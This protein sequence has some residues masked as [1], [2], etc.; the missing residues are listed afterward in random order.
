MS[1]VTKTRQKR[2][3]IWLMP[4]EQFAELVARSQT[5]SEMLLALDY[6]PRGGAF[7]MLKERI[8]HERLGVSHLLPNGSFVKQYRWAPR[9]HD[10]VFCENSTYN[11]GS[12]LKKKMLAVGWVNECA[13]CGI[14]PAWHGKLLSLQVDHINGERTDN[15]E[16]NLRLICPNCHSQTDTFAGKRNRQEPEVAVRVRVPRSRKVVRPS[17][18]ELQKL[19]WE[20]PTVKI[21]RRFGVSDVA[22]GKWA[23]EYDLSKPP[24]GYWAKQSA[25]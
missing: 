22:V 21:A 3:K 25:V 23:K 8:A 11:S 12:N 5:Y 17:A 20:L 1:K 6:S 2:S 16:E 10:E 13:V 19:L 4:A 14:G 9:P 15:R 7:R 18:E 24:R